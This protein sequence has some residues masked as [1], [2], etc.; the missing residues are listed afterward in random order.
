VL[1]KGLNLGLED[2]S[3]VTCHC[4]KEGAWFEPDA[5]DGHAAAFC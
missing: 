1:A 3:K 2:Q 4:G 5:I